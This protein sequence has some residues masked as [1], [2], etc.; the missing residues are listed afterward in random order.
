[1]PTYN[2]THCDFRSGRDVRVVVGRVQAG[3][4]RNA[5][6]MARERFP[7]P[8]GVECEAFEANASKLLRAWEGEGYAGMSRNDWHA[9]TDAIDIELAVSDEAARL[10]F[11]AL[12]DLAE[13]TGVLPSLVDATRLFFGA[14]AEAF[15]R[16]W[17][18]R[19]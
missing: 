10:S 15:A 12:A 18:A 19:L 13:E 6:V 2:A 1:M 9:L 14:G 16:A 8:E 7:A 11:L 5:S 3:S 17:L 4:R